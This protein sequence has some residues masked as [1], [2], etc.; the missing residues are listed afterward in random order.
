MIF[1]RI[2]I[3][4]CFLA[5][6]WFAGFIYFIGKIPQTEPVFPEKADAIIVLTGARG[7]IDAGLM[8]LSKGCAE[9]LFISGVGQKADLTD[10][11]QYLVSFPAEKTTEL[12]S[13]ISLGHFASSTEENAIESLEWIDH[14]K[15]QKIILVT[16]NYH[17]PRSLY[18]FKR[19][20]PNIVII[21]YHIIRTV[22]PWQSV[23]SFKLT[24]LEYNKLLLSLCK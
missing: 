5:L 17:M 2:L 21:P 14:N 1:F 18:L 13:S 3:I 10:L 16:S 22:N 19:M 15:H 8:L 6:L 23:A 11:S 20:M 7:R 4:L 24:F 9:E 12:K